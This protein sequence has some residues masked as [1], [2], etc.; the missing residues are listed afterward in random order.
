MDQ[1]LYTIAQC[2]RTAVALAVGLVSL[3]KVV[4]TARGASEIRA[5]ARQHTPEAI[6]ELARLAV[7]SRT[8]SVRVLAIRELLDRAQGKRT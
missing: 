6:E 4:L 3:W 1:L 2:C 7:N 8:E 5:L